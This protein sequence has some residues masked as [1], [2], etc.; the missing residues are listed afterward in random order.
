MNRRRSSYGTAYDIDIFAK[1]AEKNVADIHW[2]Y[3]EYDVNPTIAE[4]RRYYWQQFDDNQHGL[5]TVRYQQFLRGGSR[6]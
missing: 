3:M 6:E 2:Q 1:A 5:L 4:H